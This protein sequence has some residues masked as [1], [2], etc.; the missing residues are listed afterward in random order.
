MK[1]ACFSFSRGSTQTLDHSEEDGAL[2]A[3]LCRH[4]EHWELIETEPHDTVVAAVIAK[5]KQ[6]SDFGFAK[7][8]VTL[9]RSD[10]T[11]ID[12]LTHLQEELMDAVNYIE[13]LKR[14]L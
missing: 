9:D 6:R 14:E 2:Y 13:R 4:M 12:W 8:G 3:G 7:Y 10:L 1:E 11:T 5:F